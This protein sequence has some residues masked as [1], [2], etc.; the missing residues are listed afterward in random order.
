MPDGYITIGSV[1]IAFG[2]AALAGRLAHTAM[3]RM[4]DAMDVGSAES[5][6]AVRVRAEKLI[7]ALSLL[8]YGVAAAA[9]VSLAFSRFGVGEPRS[10]LQAFGRWFL[11]HGVNVVVIVIGATIVS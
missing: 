1:V 5:R 8:A 11:T 3:R 2:L 10:D 4:L 6:A 9:S 7:R